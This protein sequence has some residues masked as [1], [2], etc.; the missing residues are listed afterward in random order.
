MLVVVLAPAG[1]LDLA[2]VL[3]ATGGGTMTRETDAFA[4]AAFAL[5][6]TDAATGA[7]AAAA[8]LAFE[9]LGAETLLEGTA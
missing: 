5:V 6:A 9:L 1:E 2:A 8:V 3:D 7:L 4:L